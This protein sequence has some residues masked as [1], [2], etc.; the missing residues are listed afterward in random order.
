MAGR[1]AALAALAEEVEGSMTLVGCTA[2]EDKLQDGVPQVGCRGVCVLWQWCVC[3]V[4]GA[5]VCVVGWLQWCVCG[6]GLQWCV[7]DVSPACPRRPFK[8]YWT[9]TSRSG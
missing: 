7:Y 5:C 6:G 9:Q 3:V 1:E 4:A 2:I 8:R